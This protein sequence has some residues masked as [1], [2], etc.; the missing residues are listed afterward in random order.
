[1]KNRENKGSNPPRP[2]YISVE[3]KS[4]EIDC[5]VSIT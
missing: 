3:D 4:N 2:T 1:M 5:R